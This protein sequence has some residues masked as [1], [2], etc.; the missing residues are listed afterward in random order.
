MRSSLHAIV[1]NGDSDLEMIVRGSAEDVFY[2]HEVRPAPLLHSLTVTVFP[3][4]FLL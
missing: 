1:G 3:N 4:S 2:I